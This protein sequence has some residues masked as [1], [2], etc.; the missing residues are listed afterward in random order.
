MGGLCDAKHVRFE[1]ARVCAAISNQHFTFDL[2]PLES[3]RSQGCDPNVSCRD[4][5]FFSGKKAEVARKEHWSRTRSMHVVASPRLFLHS[6][7]FRD[8][9]Y[10]MFTMHLG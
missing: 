10:V 9:D 6:H 2:A 5:D 3:S 4:T 7:Q 8:H 1:A